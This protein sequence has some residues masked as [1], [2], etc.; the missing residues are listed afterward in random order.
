MKKTLIA[1]TLLVSLFSFGVANN[2]YKFGYGFN[3]A[4]WRL[5]WSIDED[6]VWAKNF[7]EDK[8]SRVKVGMSV[9]DVLG[10][11]GDP[12]HRDIECIN[13]CF[14]CYTWHAR[15]NADFDQRWLVFNKNQK[16]EEIRKSF[17]ID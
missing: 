7:S 4:F 12:L 13:N 10:L 9:K 17:F 5:V 1:I 6:T 3:D 15:G 11:L 2:M 16:V 8:F 14:W